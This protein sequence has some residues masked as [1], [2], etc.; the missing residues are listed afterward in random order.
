MF[1]EYQKWADDLAT[2][3]GFEIKTAGRDIEKLVAFIEQADSTVTVLG[4][5]IAEIEKG[6]AALQAEIKAATEQR[7]TE[8]KNTETLLKTML[9]LFLHSCKPF[10][11]LS[12]KHIRDCRQ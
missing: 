4:E 7:K 8:H 2:Q 3:L 12:N 1:G 5:E 11:C 9:N 6:I 10:R